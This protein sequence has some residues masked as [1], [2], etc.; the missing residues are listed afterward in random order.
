MLICDRGTEQK[1]RQTGQE[2]IHPSTRAKRINYNGIDH[3]KMKSNYFYTLYVHTDH[4][5]N[6]AL[7][8]QFNHEQVNSVNLSNFT[9]QD[10]KINKQ[11]ETGYLVNYQ[12][13]EFKNKFFK[14]L[15]EKDVNQ[16]LLKY[17]KNIKINKV[18]HCLKKGIAQGFIQI[19]ETKGLQSVIMTRNCDCCK[20]AS[21]VTIEDA[22]CQPDSHGGDDEDVLE[23]G[24]HRCKNEQCGR[25]QWFVTEMCSGYVHAEGSRDHRHCRQCPDMG[26]CIGYFRFVHC[27]KCAKHHDWGEI[28]C[29]H[30]EKDQ[31]RKFEK[32]RKEMGYDSD[33]SENDNNYN[34]D[35][36]RIM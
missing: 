33:H 25:D 5:V 2:F 17:D 29:P 18:S 13:Q 23:F 36:C 35:D 34:D 9:K 1:L 20:Q 30:C 4:D 26:K 16:L 8:G 22:L 27:Q 24:A 32:T 7:I 6:Y 11:T 3:D 19:D 10:Y 14:T 28:W 31:K 21:T 15:N 12:S